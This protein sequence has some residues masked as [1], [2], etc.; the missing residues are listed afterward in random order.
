MADKAFYE[1]KPDSAQRLRAA[2]LGAQA[3]RRDVGEVDDG[4][5]RT[6]IIVDR[7]LSMA[8]VI[9]H[10]DAKWSAELPDGA[11]WGVGEGDA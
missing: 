9:V 11:F 5:I 2:R 4:A 1:W 10:D 6:P 3:G 8:G 7:Y